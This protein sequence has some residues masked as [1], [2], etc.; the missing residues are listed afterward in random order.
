M[1]DEKVICSKCGCE[2]KRIGNVLNQFQSAGWVTSGFNQQ[3]WDQWLGT[4]CSKCHMIFCEKCRD[5]GPGNCQNC[6]GE[7]RPATRSFIKG[8]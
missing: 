4:V 6:G 3:G 7:I 2:L 8:G 5:V 1:D